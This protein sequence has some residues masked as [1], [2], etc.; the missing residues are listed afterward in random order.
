MSRLRSNLENPEFFEKPPSWLGS[1]P[2]ALEARRHATALLSQGRE[3]R[4]LLVLRLAESN[5]IEAL[6]ELLALFTPARWAYRPI[7]LRDDV[8]D[9]KTVWKLAVKD[10]ELDVF[11][12]LNTAEINL[13][14]LVLFLLLARRVDNPLRLLILDDPLHNFDELSVSTFARGFQKL[15]QRLGADWQ[16]LILLHGESDF[17]CIRSLVPSAVYKIPWL[18]PAESE[19]KELPIKFKWI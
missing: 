13:L 19:N 18:S 4:D 16:F 8:I 9:G 2:L 3:A 7:I 12:R 14:A 17:N 1:A 15:V 10:T 11:Q 6:N 5:A